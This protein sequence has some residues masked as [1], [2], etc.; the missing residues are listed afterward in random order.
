MEAAEYTKN[1][2]PRKRP[3]RKRY[4]P[5]VESQPAL[6]STLRSGDAVRSAV[7]AERNR[8]Q[9]GRA[10]GAGVVSETARAD[11]RAEVLQQRIDS[12]SALESTPARLR[13]L[14]RDRERVL[15]LKGQPE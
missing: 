3:A 13:R 11:V 7:L 8:A 2:T 12:E 10:S 4:R 6:A 9:R 5:P 14:A 15:K 1:A